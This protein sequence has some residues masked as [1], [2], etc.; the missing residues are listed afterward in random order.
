MAGPLQTSAIGTG[1]V[2]PEG[3]DKV[4]GRA[5]YAYEHPQV[6][7][8]FLFPLQATIARGRALTLD[9]S[10]AEAMDGAVH[11]L[12]PADAPPLADTTDGELAILRADRIGLRGQYLGAGRAD[13]PEQA[14]HAAATA[15]A[16]ADGV[17]D[18]VY[19]TPLEHN[20]PMEP[21]TTV[22]RWDDDELTL[23]LS[24]QGAHP[25]RDMIAPI[26]GL[27]PEQIRIISPHVGGGFG[28]K[29]M[30]HA[31]LMLTALAARAVPGR[32]VKYAVSRQQ[33]F[34]LTGYRAPT[35]QHVRL[36]ADRQGRLSALGF[37]A[38]SMSSRT[39]EF[40]ELA[41]KPVRIMY[42]AEHR[43]LTQKV[44]PLDTPVPS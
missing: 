36:G 30:P 17:I 26:L 43:R 31:D 33:M 21:H 4:R 12:T 7:P 19:T 18:A 39:K 14:R 24:T 38:V 32:P 20:N 29:G 2:R 25:A 22:A 27:G 10:A 15:L 35:S 11:V 8:L 5:R 9:T 44:V 37:D 42:A 41:I 3:A 16:G 6:D 13:T 28:S 1:P 34:A 23:W 40:P